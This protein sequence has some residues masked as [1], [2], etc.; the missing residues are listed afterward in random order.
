MI[1]RDFRFHDGGKGAALAIRV[2]SGAKSSQIQK[3]LKDGTVVVSLTGH[4]KDVNQELLSFLALELGIDQQGI[5][6]IAGQ[7]GKN[8]LVSVLK[9]QPDEIQ[10]IILEKI[11]S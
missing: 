9:M 11:A 3:V 2:K 4:S 7:E 5:Q 10:K 6:I 8:K 1:G